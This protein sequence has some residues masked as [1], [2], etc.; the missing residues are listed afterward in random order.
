MA[1]TVSFGPADSEDLVENLNHND[2]RLLGGSGSDADADTIRSSMP[3]S[4]EFG[5]WRH[6]AGRF[7]GALL[8]YGPR[9]A[10]ERWATRHLL[11]GEQN[12]WGRMSGADRRHAVGVA[13]RTVA[14]LA[15]PAGAR[16]GREVVAA[17][18]LHDVGKVDAGL[19]TWARAGVTFAGVAVGRAELLQWSTRRKSEPDGN[20]GG[21]ESAEPTRD[22]ERRRSW[23][24]RIGVYLAHDQVGVQMLSAAGSDGFTI[25]WAAEHHLPPAR[26]SVDPRL[27]EALKLAD[28]D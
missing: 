16:A 8:P 26:W 27:G 17:A 1:H 13:R 22:G 9:H 5:S 10:D 12:L 11:P 3:S 4:N 28:D 23:R 19:G 24:Q 6:L 20:G 21:T 18:L 7:F 25:A 15:S 2:R 14:D